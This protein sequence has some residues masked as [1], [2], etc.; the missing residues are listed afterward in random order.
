[1][2]QHVLKIPAKM[3]INFQEYFPMKS[4]EFASIAVIILLIVMLVQTNIFV[5]AVKADIFKKIIIN[6]NFQ[7]Y[8]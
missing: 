7:N 3:K 5:L 2:F 1:M 6:V 4:S 8:N